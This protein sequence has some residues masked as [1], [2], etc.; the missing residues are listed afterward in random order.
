LKDEISE[1][2]VSYGSFENEEMRMMQQ[3]D[4]PSK[5]VD[6][7]KKHKT[8]FNVRSIRTESLKIGKM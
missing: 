4:G 2:E 7:K 6:E 5:N 1:D 3:M 8:D